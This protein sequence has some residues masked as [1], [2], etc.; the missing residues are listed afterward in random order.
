MAKKKQAKSVEET[1]LVQAEPA[2]NGDQVVLA[3]A[4]DQTLECQIDNVKYI[5]KTIL[6]PAAREQGIRQALEKAGYKLK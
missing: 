6:V 3:S 4:D 1:I 2:Q 5:G